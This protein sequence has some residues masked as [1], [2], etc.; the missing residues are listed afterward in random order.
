MTDQDSCPY[1]TQPELYIESKLALK[2]Y[3][4]LSYI[5]RA[6]IEAYG[7]I[8]EAVKMLELRK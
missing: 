3:Q 5:K 2:E 6:K 8:V 1:I 4:K 7:Y